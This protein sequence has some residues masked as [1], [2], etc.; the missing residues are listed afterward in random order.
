MT[1]PVVPV[2]AGAISATAGMVFGIPAESIFAGFVGA[3]AARALLANVEPPHGLGQWV[4]AFLGIV[5]ATLFAAVLTPITTVIL[6]AYFPDAP[7]VPVYLLVGAGLGA[8]SQSLVEMFRAFIKGAGEFASS[9]LGRIFG[10]KK[11]GGP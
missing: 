4:L 11:E 6:L 7:L 8:S 3:L 2:I 1:E 9:N 10:I 5:A